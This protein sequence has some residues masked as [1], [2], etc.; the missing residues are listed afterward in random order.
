M[1][2]LEVVTLWVPMS[3]CTVLPPYLTVNSQPDRSLVTEPS[4]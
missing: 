3:S 1:V 4:V 2:R